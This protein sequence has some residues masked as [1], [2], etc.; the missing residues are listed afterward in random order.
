[1]T[2]LSICQGSISKAASD[3]ELGSL[4]LT[5]VAGGNA[6]SHTCTQGS[7]RPQQSSVPES[8]NFGGFTEQWKWLH[9]YS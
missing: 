6:G 3:K 1:M 2:L 8:D 4:P 9:A 7:C 5:A